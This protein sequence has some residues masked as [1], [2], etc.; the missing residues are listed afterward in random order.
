MMTVP[1]EAGRV[2]W[3]RNGAA[4]GDVSQ[5]VFALV[6]A[7]TEDLA[8]KPAAWAVNGFGDWL[9]LGHLDDQGRLQ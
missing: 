1:L 8:R 7:P 6:L 5:M 3:R 9:P 2:R 4:E